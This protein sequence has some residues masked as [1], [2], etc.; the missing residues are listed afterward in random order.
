MSPSEARGIDRVQ[1]LGTALLFSTGGAAIKACSLTAWQVAAFRSGIAAIA[2]MLFLPE[3]RR[4]LA[5]RQLVVGLAYAATMVLYVTA[6]KLTTAAN[7]IFLQS[8]APLYVLLLGPRLL[9]ERARATDLGFAAALGAGMTLFF[10][11]L[12]PP[13]TTAPDLLS[14]NV[15]GVASGLAWA[16]TILG[17]RWLGRTGAAAAP[18]G[19]AAAVVGGNLIAALAC[20]PLA[21]PVTRSLPVDWALVIYLGVFQIGAAYVLMTRGVRRLPA[22]EVALLLLLEPVLSVVWAWL[23]HGERPGP[24]SLAGCLTVLAVTVWRA[25]SNRS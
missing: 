20:L 8:T 12:D 19:V 7:A 10:V 25:I 1:I 11:G 16:L 23:V 6:N 13:Q 21:L 4:F 5:R 24:W 14:G 18:G 22:F 17:L 3:S 15:L 2:L 9:G